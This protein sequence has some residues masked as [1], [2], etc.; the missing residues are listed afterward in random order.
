MDIALAAALRQRGI[1]VL[2]T[3]EA[4]N[5]Q[6]KDDGQLAFATR[7][8]RALFTH[9]RSDFARLHTALM[10][11]GDSH[12][13]IILSDQLPLRILLRRLSRLCFSLTQE[14]MGNRLEFLG[15]WR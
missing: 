7:S 11:S 10:E 14:E 4:G 13:G 12:A 5:S 1:D 8:G 6:Q 3:L 15:S 2:T 9:N